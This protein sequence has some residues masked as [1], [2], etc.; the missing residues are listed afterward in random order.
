MLCLKSVNLNHPGMWCSMSR[1]RSLPD[2]ASDEKQHYCKNLFAFCVGE[3]VAKI[4][5]TPI[6]GSAQYL[7]RFTR[8]TRPS[9][10]SLSL[11]RL[12]CIWHRYQNQSPRAADYS[13]C[14]QSCGSISLETKRN[15]PSTMALL[16]TNLYNKAVG[17]WDSPQIEIISLHGK[18][19][20]RIPRAFLTCGG[21]NTWEYVVHTVNQLVLETGGWTTA[22]EHR[23]TCS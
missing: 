21:H 22:P 19:I 6:P 23:S 2:K 13:T 18:A 7:C 5:T 10:M 14:C 17:S 11:N 16:E 8:P 4:M 9:R 20:A 3:E 15:I 12:L 1:T